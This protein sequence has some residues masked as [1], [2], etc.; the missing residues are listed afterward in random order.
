MMTYLHHGACLLIDAIDPIGTLDRRVYERIGKIF[1]ETEPYEKYLNTGRQ[2]F[3]VALYYDLDGKYDVD[4]T[5][6]RADSDAASWSKMPMQ[7]A[8]L[9]AARSLREHHIPYGVVNN[10]KLDRAKEGN[11]L[12]LSDI[13]AMGAEQIE[14]A[15]NFVREGGKL[16]MSGRSAPEL[17][18]QIFDLDF[19]GYTDESVTYISPTKQGEQ[20][21]AGEFT[22]KYPLVMF[23]KQVIANGTP[24][25]EV[26][27]TR[28]LPYTIPNPGSNCT[29]PFFARGGGEMLK[30]MYRFASIHSNPPG[31][32]TDAPALVRAR[33]GKGEAVWSA[34]PFEKAN[35]E[36]HS[37]IFARIISSL[38]GSAPC[39]SANAP[40]TVE[41]VLFDAPE[42]GVKLMG[43]I[44]LQEGFTTQPVY[45]FDVEVA[46]ERPPKRV[47]LLPSEEPLP[48]I[49]EDGRVKV[50]FDH[51]H[52]YAM[53]KI[54]L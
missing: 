23:E 38:I 54:E 51:L 13:P 5:P 50:H 8:I 36:Q 2:A 52:Y 19:A 41:C 10:W 34:L 45:N 26:L 53:Y 20:I 7:E 27:G 4:Q 28:T 16:Y 18:K 25:G 30:N 15:L 39:F 14:W 40:Q 3:D 37:N 21:F 29:E 31:I 33:Y 42:Q 32:Y 46:C 22:A 44:N 47:S 49:Y 1:K 9:G 43:L 35:R 6:G 12:V 48:Y 11:V 24:K 17:L